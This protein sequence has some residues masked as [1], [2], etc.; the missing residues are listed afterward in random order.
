MNSFTDASMKSEEGKAYQGN[1]P[2]ILDFSYNKSHEEGAM[3]E[4][5]GGGK[6]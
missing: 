5:R 6:E 1:C 4:E 2:L 3:A